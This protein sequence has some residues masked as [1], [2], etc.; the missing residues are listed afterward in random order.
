V[1]TKEEY[2][3]MPDVRDQIPPGEVMNLDRDDKVILVEEHLADTEPPEVMADPV[4]MLC[5]LGRVDRPQD[6]GLNF[7]TASGLL[8]GRDKG[9]GQKKFVVPFPRDYTYIMLASKDKYPLMVP[10]GI[11]DINR[12][13]AMGDNLYRAAQYGRDAHEVRDM[14]TDEKARE[15]NEKQHWLFPYHGQ[16]DVASLVIR[17]IH[18]EC[19][20]GTRGFYFL[21]KTYQGED[22]AHHTVLASLKYREEW[23]RRRLLSNRDGILEFLAEFEGSHYVQTMEDSRVSHLRKNGVQ[24]DLTQGVSSTEALGD[25]WEALICLA[26]IYEHLELYQGRIDLGERAPELRRMASRLR[27]Q[28]LNLWMP[29]E[30][31]F[32]MGFDRDKRG[33]LRQLDSVKAISAFLLDTR[34]FTKSGEDRRMVEMFVRR[35]F[36]SDLFCAAGFRTLSSE[37][38][39]FNPGRYHLGSI[40]PF[41]CFRIAEGLRRHG[42]HHLAHKVYKIIVAIFEHFKMWPELIRGELDGSFKISRYRIRVY[43]S[44]LGFDDTINSVPQALQ[45][46]SVSAHIG[47]LERLKEELPPIT[48]FEEHLLGNLSF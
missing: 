2:E 20:N 41:M 32:A 22:G 15:L 43:N 37:H 39:W 30:E 34:L 25:C 7:I 23:L 35:L 14:E 48:S 8:P 13:L 21:N 10:E 26:E 40:W 17:L 46:W 5:L 31:Y 24:A 4:H 38:P 18:W 45:G 16:I 3:A 9:K 36:Q 33:Q 44:R 19:F 1:P 12:Y 11:L 27:K 29:D 42:F 6:L 28:I 47:A